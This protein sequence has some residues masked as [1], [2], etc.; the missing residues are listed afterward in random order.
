MGGKNREKRQRLG[1]NWE[2]NGKKM[3]KRASFSQKFA[4]NREKI[5]KK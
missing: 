4:W 1:K 5:G 3:G 2:K